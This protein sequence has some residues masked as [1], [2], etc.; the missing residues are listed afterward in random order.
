[1]KRVIIAVATLAFFSSFTAIAEESREEQCKRYAIE[2]G[3][4][5]EEMDEYLAEC[6][7]DAE[8][9]QSDLPT[10]EAIPPIEEPAQESAPTGTE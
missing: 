1:M 9:T 2:D 7:A 5:A 3:I 4:P 6:L 8:T 10:E